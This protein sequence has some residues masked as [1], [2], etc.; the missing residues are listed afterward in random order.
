MRR[1]V[2]HGT[3]ADPQS[4][5]YAVERESVNWALTISGAYRYDW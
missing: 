2:S 4:V 1:P 5:R 3:C